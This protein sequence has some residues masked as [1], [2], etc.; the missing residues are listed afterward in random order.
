MNGVVDILVEPD[1]VMFDY[2][3][4]SPVC[5]DISPQLLGEAAAY[6]ATWNKGKDFKFKWCSPNED[7]QVFNERIARYR[8]LQRWKTNQQAEFDELVTAS[9]ALEG[10]DKAA[11]LKEAF[12]PQLGGLRLDPSVILNEAEFTKKTEEDTKQWIK[13]SSRNGSGNRSN[14]QHVSS[15]REA[16]NGSH[17]ASSTSKKYREGDEPLVAGAAANMNGKTV[18]LVVEIVAIETVTT[19]TTT[20]KA[21]GIV[22]AN[23]MTSTATVT[24]HPTMIV[25]IV[26]MT[27]MSVATTEMIEVTTAMIEAMTEVIEVTT[28][29]IEG[30]TEL[31]KGM[32]EL[33]KGMTE[34]I[35]AMIVAATKTSITGVILRILTDATAS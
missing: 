31:I 6:I 16:R 15:K 14:D 5:V 30:M 27:E 1:F 20:M 12:K 29:L 21:I 11:K 10:E 3:F 4:F 13:T 9:N 22:S 19:T 34:L 26:A 32:T 24:D 7:G 25:M 35:E 23:E 18:E 17:S 2:R 8:S 28:E 33:I